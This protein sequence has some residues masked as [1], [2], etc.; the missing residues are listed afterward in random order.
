MVIIGIDPGMSGAISFLRPGSMQL[1]VEDMP[2]YKNA[3]GKTETNL[4]R[5][6]SILK[7]VGESERI[8]A[9]IE[10]VHA[11]PKQGV[12]STFRFGEN[13][14]AIQMACTG[15]GYEMHYVTPQMWKKHFRLSSDKGVSR[16]LATQRFPD[17]AE[18]FSRVKDDGRA[19]AALLALYGSETI[20]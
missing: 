16:S 9:V 5:L 19:E 3:K 10:K 18:L 7:P 13:Y 8:I 4:H 1:H 14:G 6:A 12:S 20:K 11:M 2:L 17:A 15:H